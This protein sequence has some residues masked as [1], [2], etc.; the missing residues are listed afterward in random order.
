MKSYSNANGNHPVSF[1]F[2]RKHLGCWLHAQWFFLIDHETSADSL[3]QRWFAEAQ[4]KEPNFTNSIRKVI[5]VG[6]LKN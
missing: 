6:C 5:S 2:A 4:H 1:L 3:I